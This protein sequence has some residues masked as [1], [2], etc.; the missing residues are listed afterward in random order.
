MDVTNNK[1]EKEKKNQRQVF[2]GKKKTYLSDYYLISFLSFLFLLLPFPRI[3]K[4]ADERKETEREWRKRWVSLECRFLALLITLGRFSLS[5]PRLSR[6]LSFL[7]FSILLSI[8]SSDR[9][10]HTDVCASIESIHQTVTCSS[11]RIHFDIFSVFFCFVLFFFTDRKKQT[12]QNNSVRPNRLEI[13]CYPSQ[14]ASTRDRLV[15]QL[16]RNPSSRKSWAFDIL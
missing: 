5:F 11:K 1:I 6:I 9:L 2:V 15:Q 8:M 10:L 13:S 4:K 14:E 3:R 7:F 12:K 16:P